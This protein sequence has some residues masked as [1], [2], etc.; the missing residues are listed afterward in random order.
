LYIYP[1]NLKAKATLWFW[2]LSDLLILGVLLALSV[3]L[4]STFRF[5]YM[6]MCSIL[7]AILTIRVEEYSMMEFLKAAARF[8]FGQKLY[9]GRG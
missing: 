3:F 1:E 8:F 5:P 9:Y 2:S 6:L 7:F 4:L